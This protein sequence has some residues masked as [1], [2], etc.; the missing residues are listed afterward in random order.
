MNPIG[1][2]QVEWRILA[3]ASLLRRLGMAVGTGQS[4]DAV[5]ALGLVDLS[6]ESQVY[7]ALRAIFLDSHVNEPLF[8][9]AFR[10]F[11]LGMRA[12]KPFPMELVDNLRKERPADSARPQEGNATRTGS[13]RS[14]NLTLVGIESEDEQAGAP[15]ESEARAYSAA[16]ALRQKDF[17]ELDE[18]ELERMR[19]LLRTLT[20]E[21]LKRRVR[22]TERSPEGSLLD[23]RQVAR[24]NLRHGGEV[25]VLP[26]RRH[27]IRNRPLVL[28]CD[29]S[30]SMDRYTRLLLQ[31]LHA[32]VQRLEG[33]EVFVFG[34]RLKTPR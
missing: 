8:A 13:T 27:K 11:W 5:R 31:F 7:A 25:I 14:T 29:V 28:L 23:L 30:G 21:P 16:E 12:P 1:N 9:A 4:L 15:E 19:R 24:R 2:D 22:R 32:T 26:R 3:F 33:V 34:T 20:F 10:S 17:G 6:S 18:R